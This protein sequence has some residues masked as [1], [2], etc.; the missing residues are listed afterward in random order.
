MEEEGEQEDEEDDDSDDGW[1]TLLESDDSD[2]SMDA[3]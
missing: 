2:W 3:L 1:D